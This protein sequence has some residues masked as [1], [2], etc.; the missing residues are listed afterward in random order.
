MRLTFF[1]TPEF[2]V[3]ILSAAATR[4]DVA[5]VITQPDQPSGR[6]KKLVSP[7]I[8]SL[9]RELGIPALQFERV[10]R[11]ESLD[12]L[13]GL[14]ADIFVTAAYGQILSQK[15]LDIPRLGT[16]NVH[17]SLL[18]KYRGA[19]PAQWAIING[20][21][22]TGVTTMLTDIG[23]DTGD[24]LL[25]KEE[26]IHE[27]DTSGTLLA[28]LS[29][30]GAALLLET[31]EGIE[32]GTIARVKQDDAMATHCAMLT[33]EHGRIDW[34]KSAEQ[35]CN[36]V[37][38]VTPWPGA[39][40]YI[41]NEMLKIHSAQAEPYTVLSDMQSD[42]EGGIPGTVVESSGKTGLLVRCSDGYL[43][44]LEVQLAG[45]KRLAARDFLMGHPVPVGTVL[46]GQMQTRNA[47]GT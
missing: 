42:D 35:V 5:A 8:V 29:V 6:G 14:G 17:A 41:G 12:A 40:T 1:G 47:D 7:P 21:T 2:A 11:K 15:V 23:I 25:Q 33:K 22:M 24:I 34:M 45:G 46:G 9:A 10:R 4:H 19:A 36:L 31:L 38:G 27:S 16:V 30:V 3:P 28:R 32:R 26:P 39:Y 43:R 44:L 20:E 18:P 37:R 13:R